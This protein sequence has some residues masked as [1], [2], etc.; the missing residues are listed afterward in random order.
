MLMPK[1]RRVTLRE[2]QGCPSGRVKFKSRWVVEREYVLVAPHV[3]WASGQAVQDL[4]LECL[5]I[6][7][8]F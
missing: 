8:P 7:A 3:Q 4:A 6:I 5:I 1:F 2:P